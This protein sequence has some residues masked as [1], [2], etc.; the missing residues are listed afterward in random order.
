MNLS[1]KYLW[2]AVTALAA[3]AQFP[4]HARGFELCSLGGALAQDDGPVQRTERRELGV[5]RE[6]RRRALG[7]N[8]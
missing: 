1:A 5:T 8:S 7:R 6:W 3:V 2:C 4:A